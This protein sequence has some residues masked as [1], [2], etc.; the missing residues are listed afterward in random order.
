MEL[1]SASFMGPCSLALQG[2]GGTFVLLVIMTPEFRYECWVQ[3]NPKVQWWTWSKLWR[4]RL[5]SLL[6]CSNIAWVVMWQMESPGVYV[7]LPGRF[8]VVPVYFGKHIWWTYR[9]WSFG[10]GDF[11]LLF[12]PLPKQFKFKNFGL[13]PGSGSSLQFLAVLPQDFLWEVGTSCKICIPIWISNVV[14]V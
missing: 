11:F 10:V 3:G 13:D 5:V 14:Q 2:S 6:N 4:G 7:V 8:C 1:L 12:P 9:T